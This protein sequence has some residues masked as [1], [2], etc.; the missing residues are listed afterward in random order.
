MTPAST[1]TEKLEVRT[2]RMQIVI[3]T[4]QEN[5]KAGHEDGKYCVEREPEAKA[6]NPPA[7]QSGNSNAEQERQKNRYT[8]QT[9]KRP[10]VQVPLQTRPSD[11]ATSH[12]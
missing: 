2:Y 3:Q 5:Q 7:E 11:P 4:Q 6:R 12:R 10:L 1:W 9:R 8:T